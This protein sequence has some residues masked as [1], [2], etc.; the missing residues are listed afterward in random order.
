[1]GDNNGRPERIFW[2]L[3]YE[4]PQPP[5]PFKVYVAAFHGEF[6]EKLLESLREHN[7]QWGGFREFNLG[8]EDTIT[9][10]IE[11]KG[12]SVG[13]KPVTMNW[14]TIRFANYE[15]FD[16]IEVSY[17]EPSIQ[18]TCELKVWLKR[19]KEDCVEGYKFSINGKNSENN[20]L[21]V[22]DNDSSTSESYHTA[23]EGS[24]PKWP[25]LDELPGCASSNDRTLDSG[26]M[27]PGSAF[28]GSVGSSLGSAVRSYGQEFVSQTASPIL[29]Q[30]PWA[31]ADNQD[32]NLS[33]ID[34]KFSEL[35]FDDFDDEI[36][37]DIYVGQEL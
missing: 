16:P 28:I 12:F 4:K 5:T 31:S 21:L 20:Q 3:T 10:E 17:L 24:P 9:I 23:S 8:L 35:K 33:G 19:L 18:E 26:I 36:E 11:A 25:E 22:I 14:N 6:E 1:M 37:G 13:T 34:Q 30:R 15:I 2:T 32:S 7:L 29:T 27:S